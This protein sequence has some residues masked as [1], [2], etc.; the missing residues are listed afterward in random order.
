MS[1][2]ARMCQASVMSSLSRSD[3]DRIQSQQDQR[4][5]LVA[6]GGEEQIGL[7]EQQRLPFGLVSDV[8]HRNI[9]ANLPS[10]AGDAFRIRPDETLVADAEVK[11]LRWDLIHRRQGQRNPPHVV[12]I[13][14][15]SSVQCN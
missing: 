12:S 9:D 10:L 1:S 7:A 2:G 5:I 11:A 14:H 15:D 8:E 6:P 3:A 13:G 4:P